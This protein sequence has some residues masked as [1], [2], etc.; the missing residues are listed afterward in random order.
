MPIDMAISYGSNLGFAL[1]SVPNNSQPMCKRSVAQHPGKRLS[2]TSPRHAL[3]GT[4]LDVYASHL[5]VLGAACAVFGVAFGAEG[6][7]GSRPS[8]FADDS[9]PGTR[10]GLY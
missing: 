5:F 3:W 9:F 8:S 4:A 2:C 7:F 6:L 10:R 1:H